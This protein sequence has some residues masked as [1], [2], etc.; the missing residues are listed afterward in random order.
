[1]CLAYK[2]THASQNNLKSPGVTVPVGG[3][4]LG[5]DTEWNAGA[6]EGTPEQEVCSSWKG[7]AGETNEHQAAQE[8]KTVVAE[9][10]MPR[11]YTLGSDHTYPSTQMLRFIL[12]PSTYFCTGVNKQD[13]LRKCKG[14]LGII[15]LC[16]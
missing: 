4:L 10:R 6:L 16:M 3:S 9:Q 2:Q 8:N 14:I 5:D 7:Q 1:M 13:M 12:V 15:F 11:A